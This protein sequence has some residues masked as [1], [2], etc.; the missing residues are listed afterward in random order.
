MIVYT[1]PTFFRS[2]DVIDIGL[3]TTDSAGIALGP[4]FGET[5]AAYGA[6]LF[7]LSS[8]RGRVMAG[9][10]ALD[11]CTITCGAL[12]AEGSYRTALAAALVTRGAT[13]GGERPRVTLPF[14][15][16]WRGCDRLIDTGQALCAEHWCALPFDVQRGLLA[17]YTENQRTT[18]LCT[19]AWMRWMD[20]AFEIL[21]VCENG[22]PDYLAEARRAGDKAFHEGLNPNVKQTRFSAEEQEAMWAAWDEAIN[23]KERLNAWMKAPAQSGTPPVVACTFTAPVPAP[24]PKPKPGPRPPPPPRMGQHDLLSADEIGPRVESAKPRRKRGGWQFT[25]G[26]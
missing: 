5:S 14:D 7:G 23:A 25:D 22:M 6:R 13:L 11:A 16:A 15:C 9:L 26:K 24:P 10:L 17:T 18:G 1:A 20:L 12:V 4:T 21:D 8:K 19:P 2:D 3:G